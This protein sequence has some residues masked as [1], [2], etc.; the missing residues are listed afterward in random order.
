VYCSGWLTARFSEVLLESFG[1]EFGGGFRLGGGLGT[2][3]GLGSGWGLSMSI[4]TVPVILLSMVC[5][6]VVVPN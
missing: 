2:G 5:I 1:V 4:S 3:K 6:V